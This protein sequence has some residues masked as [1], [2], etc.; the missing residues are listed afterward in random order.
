MGPVLSEDEG[1]APRRLHP[2]KI[3]YNLVPDFP[4]SQ[5]T[6]LVKKSEILFGV[7]RLPLDALAAFAALLLS[8]RLREAGINLFPI[9]TFGDV[10]ML[11]DMGTYLRTFV[12]PSVIA[13]VLLAACIGLY[14]L[15]STMSAWRESFGV[16]MVAALW[17]VLVIGWYAL[18]LRAFFPSRALLLYA[19]V[20]IVVFV[21]MGRACLVLLQ[22]AFLR[23][24]YGRRVVVSIGR[25]AL[26]TAALDVLREEANYSY[27]GHLSDL[28]A[29]RRISHQHTIDLVLQ[30]DPNPGSTET[31]SLIDFCRSHHIGYGFLPP[32]LADVPHQLR[33]ERLGLLPLVRLQPTPLD[34]WGRVAKR[35]F[36]F[37]C[38][39]I[40]FVV[41]LPVFLIIAIAIVIDSGFPIF[42]VS[43][44]VGE[45]G[46]QKIR[47]FK[48]RSMVKDADAQ[49]QKLSN[50][51]HRA[52]GPLFKVRN[53][54]RVTRVGK[55]LRRWTLDELPQLI[56]VFFGTVSLVGPRPHLPEEV[57][58]Y[59]PEQRRVFAIKPGMTGLA[60]ISGRSDLSFEEEAQ[61]D[62]RYV[63]EW[64]LLLDIWVLWR[65][66]F[67][68]FGR[69][70]AD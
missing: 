18:V 1:R 38:S 13:I 7:L 2:Y 27:L 33:V 26:S 55:I 65:T 12:F 9:Q 56:N 49:K 53:D 20:F 21:A 30:T 24:G 34:G 41:L 50:L 70:G 25:Q 10:A 29:L 16:I 37:V 28:G 42:Y 68:V 63:E 54:P 3:Q 57:D 48:F 36:D 59:S 8:Y 32:V 62:L 51:N 58:R 11:P 61:L 66:A 52:D 14:T 46:R 5:Y 44:R 64:S 22:R 19:T 15:R 23:S 6:V 43:T 4:I 60:Q 47:I 40:L 39:L 67:T 31:L 35:I 45:Q 17:L 69:R